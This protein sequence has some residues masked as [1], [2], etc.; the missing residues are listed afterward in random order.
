MNL[1]RLRTGGLLLM[2]LLV[3]GVPTLALAQKGAFETKALQAILIDGQSGSILYAHNPDERRPPASMSKLMT[4][5]MIFKGLKSKKLA[6]GDEIV[7]SENAWRTGG[8]P[9]R[10]SSMFV[11]IHKSA[12]LEQMIRGLVIQSGNDAAIAVAEHIAGSEAFSLSRWI[13]RRSVSD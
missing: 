6:L 5:V 2:G 4:L 12:T 10:T 13:K 7:V 1:D 11:P 9:S 8:A 3:V